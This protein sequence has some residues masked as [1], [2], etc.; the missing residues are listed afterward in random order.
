MPLVKV[1]IVED[2][3]Y[4]IKKVEEAIDI[5]GTGRGWQRVLSELVSLNDDDWYF[6]IIELDDLEK[7][8]QQIKVA[9][10]NQE[11]IV[12]IFDVQ[13]MTDTSIGMD[14]YLAARFS[15]DPSS[16]LFPMIVYTAINDAYNQLK[17]KNKKQSERRHLI[18]KLR[19]EHRGEDVYEVLCMAISQCFDCYHP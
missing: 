7:A 6:Q 4:A 12:V 14:D 17:R 5:V 1:L 3:H 8:Q 19:P 11:K 13:L 16:L 10:D 18:H 15:E 9:H 2:E